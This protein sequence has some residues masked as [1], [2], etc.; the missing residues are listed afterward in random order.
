MVMNKIED[1]EILK[2]ILKVKEKI[3]KIPTQDNYKLYGSFSINS[4]L[5]RKPWNSWLKE[6]FGAINVEYSVGNGMKVSNEDLLDNLRDLISKLGR[7]PKQE[8]LKLGKYS[9][10]AYKRAF[11]N[12]SSAL[13]EIGKVANVQFNL[14]DEDILNDIIRIKNELQIVP[15]IESFNEFS[16]TVTSATVINRFGSWNAAIKKA[17]F[18][19]VS[20]RNIPKEDVIEALRA[21]VEKNDNDISYLEYWAIRKANSLGKFPY[22]PNTISDKFDNKSWEDIMKE[23]GYDYKSVNQF[24]KR[25]CFNGFDGRTYL[26]SIEKQVGDFLFN[27]KKEGEIID[28][29][30]EK[31]VCEDRAWTCDF[32]VI[33]DSGNLWLEIDGMLASR[34]DPYGSGKNEKIEYYK[35]NSFDYFVITYKLADIFKALKEKL[36]E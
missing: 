34:K 6:I 5:N 2:D 3:G 11:G 27:L 1:S 14:S 21:W 29:E 17:G 4:L 35:N 22:S 13:K 31:K 20:N 9:K 10:N 15:C 7:V 12:Y 36:G 8:E 26:S 25:G 16:K 18:E 23:C 30:Y 32:Y 24:F 19:I 33:K 28:Y